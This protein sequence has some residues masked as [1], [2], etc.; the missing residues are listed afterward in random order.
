[1][2]VTCSNINLNADLSDW[3]VSNVTHM[4]R[5]LKG[6]SQFN[7]VLSDWNTGK[8]IDMESMFSGCR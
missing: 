5:M 2:V 7:G 8:C 3:D 4:G 6:C 1:M